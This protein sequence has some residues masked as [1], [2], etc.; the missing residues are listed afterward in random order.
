M[1]WIILSLRYFSGCLFRVSPDGDRKEHFPLSYW[2]FWPGSKADY[3]MTSWGKPGCLKYN[4]QKLTS[5]GNHP[6][7][8]T[9][10]DIVLPIRK[11][12]TTWA[13]DIKDNVSQDT[14][15]GGWYGRINR[16]LSIWDIYPRK[17]GH[18][19]NDPKN[20]DFRGLALLLKDKR[21]LN[22]FS[23]A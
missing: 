16:K 17:G 14:S 23:Q 3:T 10:T 1:I 21:K 18:I 6:L 7:C 2:V 9:E 15:P 13:V 12:A 22:Y 20:I 11:V 4:K 8:N 19:G 5:V